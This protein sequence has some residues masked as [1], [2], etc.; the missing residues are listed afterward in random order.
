MVR[1]TIRVDFDD[2]SG[3]GPGKV[4][5]L[6][7]VEET[8]SIRKS[9]AAMKMSYRQGWLLLKALEETFGRPLVATATGGRAGGGARLSPLGKAVVGE[10][11][12]L[13][14]IAIKAGAKPLASL[15]RRARR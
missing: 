8:G 2:G 7:L 12:T 9:A 5:L 10:Y 6:E 14:R 11:R 15:A 1:L 3:L 4:K 13:E